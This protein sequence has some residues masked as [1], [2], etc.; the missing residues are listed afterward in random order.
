MREQGSRSFLGDHASRYFH[1]SNG[2]SLLL[3]AAVISGFLIRYSLL[4]GKS[5]LEYDDAISLLAATGH[6]GEY[7]AISAEGLEPL[8]EWVQASEWK[9]MIEPEAG[10][11]LGVVARDL[12]EHD[13][14]PPLYFWIL[15]AWTQGFGT[16]LPALHALNLLFDALIAISLI[17]IG[18]K[19]WNSKRE[20]M[21]LAAA[22]A[23][24]PV[25]IKTTPWIRQ[26]VMLSLLALL[27]AY[28][29]F[30]SF[31][32]ERPR[33]LI[34][35]DYGLLATAT[36]GLLTHYHFFVLLLVGFALAVLSRRRSP[37]RIAAFALVVG[38]AATIFLAFNP[39]IVLSLSTYVASKLAPLQ[40]LSTL[41]YRLTT[42]GK[43][44]VL[45]FSPVALGVGLGLFAWV[46]GRYNEYTGDLSLGL[47]EKITGG[48]NPMQ[49]RKSEKAA[50]LR[51]MLAL[52]ALPLLIFALLYFVG[53]SPRHAMSSRYV[54][55]LSTTAAFLPV[56]LLAGSA[57]RSLQALFVLGMIS[58]GV[59]TLVPGLTQAQEGELDLASLQ[60][61]PAVVV[62]NIEWGTWPMIA[63]HLQDDQR[64]YVSY[65]R[66][67]SENPDAWLD[68]LERGGVYAS[69]LRGPQQSGDREVVLERLEERY[70]V[71]RLSTLRRPG[72]WEITLHRIDP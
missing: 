58:V 47:S 62:D 67:L 24:N 28:F 46:R 36:A 43:T 59:A 8:G 16:S 42:I 17:L 68:G 61:A 1:W 5:A 45:L 7:A 31:G 25:A 66:D 19:E 48:D 39:G 13:I 56:I 27:F 37:V 49:D 54:G 44:T 53:I 12:A 64:L 14:H 60:A 29:L 26:Y 69:I 35:S 9:R 23:L 51:W 32:R 52:T 33:R 10:R 34:A 65:A 30:R 38:V 63:Q 15:A 41:T 20:G 55:W 4:A 71:K 2:L 40:A 11:G 18:K 3:L 21:L 50:L 72:D 57:K 6:E 22:W 70:S